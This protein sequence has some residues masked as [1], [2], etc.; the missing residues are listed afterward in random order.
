MA[1]LCGEQ[2][3]RKAMVISTVAA[4][5][6]SNRKSAWAALAALS[7]SMALSSLSAS[8]ATIAL[9]ALATA[10]AA[11]F[12]HVQWVVIAY[13]LAVT[14]AIV[15]VGRLGDIVGR[16]RLLLAGL[17]VFTV[18]SAL[19]AVAPTLPLLVAARIG[20]G[21]GAAV[22]MALTIALI[23]ETVPKER[24][25]SAMGLLGA[26]SAVGT[27]LGPSLGGVLIAWFGWRSVFLVNLPLGLLAV[28]AAWRFLPADFATGKKKGERFD[29][30][31]TLALAATLAVL[32]LAMTLGKGHFGMLN[33][34]LLAAALAGA[35]SFAAIE[36]RVASPLIKLSVFADLQFSAGLATTAMSMVAMMTTLLVGPFYLSGALGLDPAE[37]GAII[38][39]GPVVGMVGGVF[40]GRIVDRVG[41]SSMVLLGLAAMACGSAL[42]CLLPFVFGA[43]GYVGAMLVLSPGYVLFQAANNTAVMMNVPA[44]RRGV[45]SG[46][47][48]L[49]RNLGLIVGATAMGAL[50]AYGTGTTDPTGA[51]PA[52]VGA[53]LRMTFGAVALLL[54]AA[55]AIAFGARISAGRSPVA[56]AEGE[57]SL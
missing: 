16:R 37:V 36:A 33:A 10:F 35:G 54:V 11:P 24:T 28:A 45:S 31:G 39:V 57:K 18:A 53:G 6:A 41:V 20:Q 3:R 50:F 14:A 42:M 27:G 44:D 43:A 4:S 29:V 47:L 7:L 9:P 17:G 30:P 2:L 56:A 38:S 48:S 49:S 22:M 13:L 46:M 32:A 1:Y 34:G 55:I 8:S 12:Q 23:G 15:S 52:A 19:C 40:A 25:G 21:L 5:D 26:M 51:A